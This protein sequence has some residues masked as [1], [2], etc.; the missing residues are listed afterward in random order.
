MAVE[1]LSPPPKK[2]DAKFD[3]WLYRLWKRARVSVDYTVIGATA[4]QMP[5]SW[6]KE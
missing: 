1:D 5:L 6:L 3:N 4:S 2:E